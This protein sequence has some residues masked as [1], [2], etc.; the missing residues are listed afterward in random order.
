MGQTEFYN[1]EDLATM[2]KVH[3]S[4]IRQHARAGRLPAIR[5]GKLFRFPKAEVDALFGVC[6]TMSGK[7]TRPT[8]ER[9][10]WT[11]LG[12][13]TAAEG[14][15]AAERDT[16]ESE[17]DEWLRAMARAARPLEAGGV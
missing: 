9:S 2:L 6:K 3:R 8:D 14:I 12:L 16:P 5:L 4:T 1:V 11:D 13:R 10:A 15:E 7:A 17:F